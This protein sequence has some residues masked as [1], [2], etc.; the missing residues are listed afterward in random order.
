L[1]FGLI[2]INNEDNPLD[3]TRSKLVLS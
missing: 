1:H 3:L 2:A